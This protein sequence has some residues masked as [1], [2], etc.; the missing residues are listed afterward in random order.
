MAQVIK[1]AAITL[2]TEFLSSRRLA[3]MMVLG[4][5]ALMI[6]G[7][8]LAGADLLHDAAHDSRHAYGFPCH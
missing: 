2:E 5:G 8:G 3:G 7:T 1:S 6:F 4:F